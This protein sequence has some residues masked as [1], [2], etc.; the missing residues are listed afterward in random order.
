M[1]TQA[2]K[3]WRLLLDGLRLRFRDPALESAFREDRFRHNIG[4]IRFAFL[5]GISLWVV[6]GVLLRPHMLAVSDL[7]L[8][9]II[10]YGVFIPMLLIGLGLTFT[11][12]FRRI[13]QGMSVVIA[14]ITILIWV[15][16][17]SHIFTLPAEYGYVGIILITSFTYT[18]LRLRFLLVVL[19]T[20]I[21]IVV[22]L[23]YAFTARY[24]VDVSRV[25]AALYLISFGVLGGLAAYRIERFSRQVFLRGR[26]VQ[27][28]RERSDG[29]LLNILPQA[30]VAQLKAS[31]GGRIA[32][33]FDQV[34]VV[35]ADAVG[36]TEQGARASPEEFA[37]A[38][39]ELF[40]RF[41]EI[42]DRQG[43]EKIKTIGDAY[44][45]V[46]GAPVPMANH[47]GAA[48]SMALEMLAEA[49]DVRWPSGDPVRV[50]VGVATGPAVAGI[51]GQRK[52]AY[53]LW[54]DTVNLASR[55]Q[56]S[57]EPGQAMAS[58]P[59]AEQLGDGYTFGSTVTIDL[60]G[61][62]PTPVRVLLGRRDD[63]PVH[64]W[65]S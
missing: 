39:D 56:E 5:A 2:T 21:G 64:G 22:Y 3:R 52:F 24:V 7:R 57:A 55:L 37:G 60:K 41:D 19:I 13:W 16:Y 62:G 65:S 42:A 4:N 48:A 38:L 43:L 61:K 8:D 10:R 50:R 35:I 63:A 23:P 40:R 36:S 6:W 20:V 51:I 31:P 32:Q 46:A 58:E 28:E 29:L 54:G 11:P 12:L 53:D 27:Q 59:T 25:L 44:M 9:A 47:A 15:Y 18:L 45:A 30:I 34:T 14:T 1:T 17:V 49:G 33:A 26:E